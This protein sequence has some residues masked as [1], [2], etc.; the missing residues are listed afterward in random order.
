RACFEAYRQNGLLSLMD[1]Q[2]AFQISSA[3]ISELLRSVQREHNI[4]VPT[5]GTVLDAGKSLTHKD[6]IV[7]LHW[8]GHS[9]REIARMTFHSPRAVDN[10]IGPFEA[11]LALRMY[12]VPPPLLARVLRKGIRLVEEHLQLIEQ[13][14][15]DET[16]I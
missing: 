6:I 16:E 5:P 4:V 14:G 15:I 11:V 3:R 2:W 7:S 12:G 10:S 1:L 13:L 8:Q 9:V